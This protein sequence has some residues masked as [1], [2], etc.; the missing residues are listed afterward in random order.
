MASEKKKSG[1]NEVGAGGRATRKRSAKKPTA[2]KKKRSQTSS[3]APSKGSAKTRSAPRRRAPRRSPR[4][5]RVAVVAGLR[6]PFCKSETLLKNL[7]TVDL[8]SEC[9]KE[10]VQ[11]SEIDPKEL[12]LCVYG[13]VV[14]TLDWLNVAREVVLAAGLPK[15]I[16][17]YSVSRACATSIQAMT[18]VTQAILCGQHDVGIAGGADSTTDIPLKVSPRLRDAL[19]AAQRAK[20]LGSR[21][22]ALAGISPKDLLPGPPGFNREPS[23]GEQMGEAAEKMAKAN[24]I[25]RQLQDEIALRSHQNAARAWADG[26]YEAE[27]MTMLPPPYDQPVGRDNIVRD[28]TD[29]EALGKLRPAFDKRYGT[30]TAGNAS[31]LTDGASALLLMRES[32]AKAL[33]YTPLGFVKSW[34]YAAVDPGWQLLMAPVFA[35]PKALERAGLT[36]EDMDLVDMHEAFAA[37]VASNLQ[38]MASK[39]FAERMMGR[40][41]PVGEVDPAKLNVNG[42]S[43]AIGHP[44]AA[45]G[46][47][48]VLSTLRELKKRG[49]KHALLTLCAA[50]GLGAAVV[51]EAS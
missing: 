44:F 2:S 40:S 1:T 45:T 35:A 51:L 37:Q 8:G 38:A 49:G 9:V 33:G 6:T 12:S 24:G 42:G 31:P 27:V 16:E 47:R 10:L 15:D 3:K 14:P 20:T 41:A 7:R 43:I 19:L 32:K 13:Q 26:T 36:L 22:K 48:M 23:T 17:A 46:G 30:I 25:S 28:D 5:D 34:A 11:R 21:L 39:T 18:D 4:A 29:M 50:G